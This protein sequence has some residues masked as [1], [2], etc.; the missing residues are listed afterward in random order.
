MYFSAYR[1]FL[2]KFY[3]FHFIM[4]LQ[5]IYS[6]FFFH[7]KFI[8]VIIRYFIMLSNTGLLTF[9]FTI[10]L[11]LKTEHKNLF[12]MYGYNSTCISISF[13][14]VLCFFNVFLFYPRALRK[15]DRSSERS[16][17]NWIEEMKWLDLL[18]S[19]NS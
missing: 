12:Y 6:T 8:S 16:N 11:F 15:L 10:Y 18:H 3:I 14:N 9:F 19:R 17:S 4:F 5:K 13:Y 7:K 1:F 2:H